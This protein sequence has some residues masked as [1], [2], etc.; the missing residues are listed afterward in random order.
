MTMAVHYSPRGLPLPGGCRVSG[1][2][3]GFCR[4][5]EKQQSFQQHA[6]LRRQTGTERGLGTSSEFWTLGETGEA[7][8]TL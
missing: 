4:E 3:E 6:R 2:A 7:G 8:H 1:P 5:K